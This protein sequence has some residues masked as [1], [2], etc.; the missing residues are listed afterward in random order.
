MPAAKGT[1][2][3]N[4]GTSQGWTDKRGYEWIYVTE[5]GKRRARRKHRVIM[6]RA[7]KR[8]LEPWEIVHHKDENPGNNAI[9]NLEIKEFGAHTTEHHDGSR[10]S[11]DSKRTM[12][13]FGLMREELKVVRSI[14]ADLLAALRGA[15]T[16]IDSTLPS[17]DMSDAMLDAFT[18]RR[19]AILAAI[20]NATGPSHRDRENA[21]SAVKG[22]ALS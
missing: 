17:P 6:E 12:E 20:A 16:L 4:A 10:H 19:D 5:N 9:E 15:M 13:A 2:P 18:R 3:W 22:D 14:N 21:Q 1:I 7:L 11:Y 8:R